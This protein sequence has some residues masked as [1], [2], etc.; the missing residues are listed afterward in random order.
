QWIMWEV[1][2][3]FEN[4]GTVYDVMEMMSKQHDI[5]DKPGAPT[6]TAKKG[7]IHYDMPLTRMAR[8]MAM[9]MEPT[10]IA[11]LSQNQIDRP[12]MTKSA[13]QLLT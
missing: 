4:I 11:P 13:T 5:V 1:S 3:L 7:A 2:A 10:E 9:A 8:P 12:E 6:L